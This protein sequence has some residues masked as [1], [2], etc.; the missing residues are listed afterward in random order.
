MGFKKLSGSESNLNEDLHSYDN[1]EP[2]EEWARNW[3]KNQ[4]DLPPYLIIQIPSHNESITFSVYDSNNELNLP[5][6]KD[7]VSMFLPCST[8]EN[9][10]KGV[11]QLYVTRIWEKLK[12][13][14]KPINF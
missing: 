7:L 4:G 12:N 10:V 6:I 1:R 9:R 8:F 3:L 2:N 14:K 5:I 11:F 13:Q